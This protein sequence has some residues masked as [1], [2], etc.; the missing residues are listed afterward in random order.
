MVVISK[1]IIVG[2]D[3]P[4]DASCLGIVCFGILGKFV[5]YDLLII[6]RFHL[7][8]SV[9]GNHHRGKVIGF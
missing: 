9:I 6:S 3:S 7:K 8:G 1:S 5:R 4:V 2:R